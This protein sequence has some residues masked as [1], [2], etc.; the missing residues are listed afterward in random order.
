MRKQSLILLG[1]C[2]LL[3]SGCAEEADQAVMDDL[4]ETIE[5]QEERIAELEEQLENAQ[6]TSDPMDQSWS[7]WVDTQ[8]ED[9]VLWHGLTI[10]EVREDLMERIDLIPIEPARYGATI[11]FSDI[12]VGSYAVLAYASDGHWE[13][14]LFLSY[15]VEDRV[16]TWTV[17][18]YTFEGQ[19]HLVNE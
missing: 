9:R 18:A 15:Q 3:L 6:A 11:H 7:R 19:V 2:I 14:Q 4:Q 17:I 10:G 13:E 1:V 16:M 5:A 8:E 12:Y